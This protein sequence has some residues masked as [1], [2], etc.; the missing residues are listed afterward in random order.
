MGY[1]FTA[2]IFNLFNIREMEEWIFNEGGYDN[3][4]TVNYHSNYVFNPKW[5]NIR[6]LPWDTLDRA[7][8]YLKGGHRLSNDIIRFIW[9]GEDISDEEKSI[10]HKNLKYD[11][12]LKDKIRVKRPNWDT[13]DNDMLRLKDIMHG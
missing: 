9:G 7:V 1:Q 10:Q 12:E 5:Q 11:V 3:G 13:I 2:S 6:Y 8:L 4:N